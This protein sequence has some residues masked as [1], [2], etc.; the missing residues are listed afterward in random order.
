MH[1]STIYA[2]QVLKINCT[3]KNKSLHYNGDDSYLL[4]NGV[5]QLQFK[6]ADQIKPYP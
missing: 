2:E 5:K 4:V 6:A 3:V 1:N